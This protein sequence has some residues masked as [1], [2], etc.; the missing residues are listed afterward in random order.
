MYIYIYI[1]IYMYR[2]IYTS[3]HVETHIPKN[4]NKYISKDPSIK[5]KLEGSLKKILSIKLI[6]LVA[7]AD[8]ISRRNKLYLKY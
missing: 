4:E 2:Y 3:I 5:E 7:L 1:Y 6:Y 8:I